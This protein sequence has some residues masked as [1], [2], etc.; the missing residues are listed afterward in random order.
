MR[1][2]DG[3]SIVAIDPTTRGLAFVFLENG[4]PLDWGERLR[5]SED[6]MHAVDT[7]L[8]GCAADLLVIE[9]PDTQGCKRR[10]RVRTLLRAIAKHARQR[11]IRVIT[12]SR[13]EVRSAWAA[14]GV[15][16]KQAMAAAI[17]ARFEELRA[18]LPPPRR[19]GDSEDPRINV[20]DATSLA[21]HACDR[22]SVLL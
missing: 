16:N 22:T 15:A 18:A 8:D 2:S 5:S 21:I 20:F 17:A 6:E 3:R 14:R 7:L 13:E 12:V 1:L 9:D 11:D 10:P 19:P 4:T